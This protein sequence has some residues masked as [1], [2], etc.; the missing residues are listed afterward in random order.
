MEAPREHLQEQYEL[1]EGHTPVHDALY[2]MTAKVLMLPQCQGHEV[3]H[4]H[5]K[6]IGNLNHTDAVFLELLFGAETF[7]SIPRVGGNI[8]VFIRDGIA[9]LA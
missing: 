9:R 3:I 5:A 2:G 6:V 4:N 8:Y 7:W 1:E